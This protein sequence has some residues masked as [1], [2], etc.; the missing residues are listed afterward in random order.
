MYK[1]QLLFVAFQAVQVVVPI[2]P[3]GLGCLAGVLLFGPWWGFV[4]N[5]IGICAG[6]LM[7]FAIARNC[8]KDVYKRQALGDYARDV[9]AYTR[10]HGRLF[11]S[12]KGYAPCADQEA[13]VETIG[14]D[15]LRDTE[16]PPDSVFCSHGAGDIVPWD[17]VSARAHVDSGL[18]LG[19]KAVP[20]ETAPPTRRGEAY[21]GTLQQDKELQAIFERTYGCLLYTSRC[22]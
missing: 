12:L 18:R 14:Y 20:E 7:A 11:C 19:E 5:Y 2:L 1:R 22:V 10:G 21:A 15:P 9:A 4:Y 13:V 17:Q 16:N 6:S 3:G 8:G